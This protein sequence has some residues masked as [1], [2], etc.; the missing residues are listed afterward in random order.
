MDSDP[1]Y[2]MNKRIIKLMPDYQCWPLWEAGGDQVG[3]IDPH[4]LPLKSETI[5][6]LERWSKIFDS[7][8]N[9]D[10]P[11]SGPE[12]SKKQVHEFNDEGEKLA[13]TL[14]KELGKAFQIIHDR[15][16]K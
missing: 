8:M 1:T 11:H 7:W 4:T 10:D 3:N 12:P 13:K 5:E 6:T 2:S 14:Q 16:F 9:L 15:K